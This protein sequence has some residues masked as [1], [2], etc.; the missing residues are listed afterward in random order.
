LRKY[1]EELADKEPEHFGTSIVFSRDE[2]EEANFATANG[3]S[4]VYFKD[5]RDYVVK[6][7]SE[8]PEDT[9]FSI[10]YSGF[11][12]PDPLNTRNLPHARMSKLHAADL[13]DDPAA[14]DSMFSGIGGTQLASKVSEY[15]DTHPEV[16]KALADNNDI[17]E[18]LSKYPDQ[19]KP[20]IARFTDNRKGNTN[21]STENKEGSE[22]SS[23]PEGEKVETP[24]ADEPK[25]AESVNQPEAEKPKEEEQKPS[26]EE[27]PEGLKTE[28]KHVE[29]SR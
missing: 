8:V 9:Y 28:E 29:L 10:D 6:S 22:Q 5:G 15:L 27:K 25:T 13:V 2:E 4:I 19:I 7:L 12:S 24:K 17:V 3:A 1:V 18:I 21:M 20:F 23:K 16:L 26:E 11:K 14:T